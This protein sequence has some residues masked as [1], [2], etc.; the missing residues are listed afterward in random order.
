MNIKDFELILNNLDKQ[1]LLSIILDFAGRDRQIKEEL[2]FRY[3][4]KTDTLESARKAS[5]RFG[6]N[7]SDCPIKVEAMN[8]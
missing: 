2:L 4:E 6:I 7:A 3:S 1:T 8:A 5:F